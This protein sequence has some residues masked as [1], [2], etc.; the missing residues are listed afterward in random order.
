[1]ALLPD[2]WI[3]RI[4]MA[5]RATYGV[6]FDRQFECPQDEDPVKF[7]TNLKAWWKRELTPAIRAPH[8]LIYALDHLPA[9]PPNLVAFKALCWQAPPMARQQQITD[10]TKA[11]PNRVAAEVAKMRKIQQVDDKAWAHRLKAVDESGGHVTITQRNLYKA[12]LKSR[13]DE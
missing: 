8:T 10:D 11:D 1:M 2:E 3:D 7:A 4:F 5:L 6:S 9:T 13:G 12:A